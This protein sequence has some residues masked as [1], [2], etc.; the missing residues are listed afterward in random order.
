VLDFANDKKITLRGLEA[1]LDWRHPGGTRLFTHYALI[2]ID[3]A[4]TRFNA[5]YE[6]S[7]PQHAFGL[8]VSQDFGNSWQASLNYEYQS[9][10]TW[11][12]EDPIHHYH[13]LDARLAKTFALGTTR[14]VAELVGTNLL[15]PFSDYLPSRNWE[16][17]VFL[18][19]SLDY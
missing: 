7:A 4:G 5:G 9:E 1:Q 8:L 11:Y 18:R 2:A 12:R 16:R 13:K 17:G 10:M 3:A 14:A 19:C 15:Q 6:H